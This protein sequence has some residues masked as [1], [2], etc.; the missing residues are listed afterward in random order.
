MLAAN[1]AMCYMRCCG[2][3]ASCDKTMQQHYLMELHL[4]P[5]VPQRQ[6]LQHRQQDG[7]PFFGTCT[8]NTATFRALRAQPTGA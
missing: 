5:F 2:A 6:L 8:A 7:V 3:Q 1:A 4:H